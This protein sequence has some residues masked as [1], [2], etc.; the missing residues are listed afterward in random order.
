[1]VERGKVRINARL[2]TKPGAV[3]RLGDMLT[4]VQPGGVRVVRVEALAVRRGPATEARDLYS[5]DDGD[6]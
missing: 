6:G 3:L 4:V 1:M 5:E 2:V